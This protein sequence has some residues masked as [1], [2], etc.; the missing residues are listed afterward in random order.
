MVSSQIILD[1]TGRLLTYGALLVTIVFTAFSFA[2][3]V[4]LGSIFPEYSTVPHA[5][6]TV[7]FSLMMSVRALRFVSHKAM[8]LSAS[9]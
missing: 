2:F 7:I 4:G 6:A 9:N 8:L 3:Y 1:S 5:F